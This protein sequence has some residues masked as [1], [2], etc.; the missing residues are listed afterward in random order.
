[1]TRKKSLIIAFLLL[2]RQFHHLQTVVRAEGHA[3]AAMDTNV[4]IYQMVQEDGIHRTRFGA[5]AATN[6]ELLLLENTAVFALRERPSGTRLSTGSRTTSKA[7]TSLEPS[8]QAA[9]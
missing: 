8:G 9:G 7:H 5:L 1:M 6:A 4:R 2:L 3:L